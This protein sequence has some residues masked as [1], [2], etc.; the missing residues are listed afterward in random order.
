MKQLVSSMLLVLAF[1]G[2]AHADTGV[3]QIIGN[4]HADLERYAASKKDALDLVKTL[5]AEIVKSRTVV[6]RYRLEGPLP[7]LQEQSDRF[8][9]LTRDADDKFGVAASRP[10]PQCVK[11]A[12]M[13]QFYWDEQLRAVETGAVDSSPLRRAK[14]YYDET[15]AECRIAVK[16]PPKAEIFVSGPP[17]SPSPA[18]SCDEIA[19]LSEETDGQNLTWVCPKNV[20]LR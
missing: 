2:H 8:T 20:R 15:V 4:N 6:D 18:L 14:K 3:Y 7:E 9:A 10:L 11:M 13:A 1:V 16:K 17:G 5:Q 12:S 19:D